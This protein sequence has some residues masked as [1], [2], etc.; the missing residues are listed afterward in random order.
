MQILPFVST[1]CSS[2]SFF[3]LVKGSGPSVNNHLPGKQCINLSHFVLKL[4][5]LD[6]YKEHDESHKIEKK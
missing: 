1:N 4:L 3:G 6:I 2:L 5:S